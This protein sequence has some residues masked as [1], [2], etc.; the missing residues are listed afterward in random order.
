ME[1][2][3]GGCWLCFLF[4]AEVDLCNL[5]LVLPPRIRCEG[6]FGREGKDGTRRS[7]HFRSIASGKVSLI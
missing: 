7:P 1:A 5:K 6:S 4:G 2:V 3:H